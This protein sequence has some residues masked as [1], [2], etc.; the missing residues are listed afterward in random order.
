MRTCGYIHADSTDSGRV[1]AILKRPLG[2]LARELPAERRLI[3]SQ[4]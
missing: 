2:H 1:N 3:F 4:K